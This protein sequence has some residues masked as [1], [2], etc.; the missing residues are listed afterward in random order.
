MQPDPLDLDWEPEPVRRP[1]TAGPV[2]T[3][4]DPLPFDFAAFEE[5]LSASIG[6]EPVADTPVVAP[7]LVDAFEADL[8]AD[9]GA[10]IAPRETAKPAVAEAVAAAPSV[11]PDADF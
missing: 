10:P 1:A 8:L 6:I 9:L 4:T 3:A 2:P 5:E 11:A 7:G